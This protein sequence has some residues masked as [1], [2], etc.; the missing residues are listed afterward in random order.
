[1]PSALTDIASLADP[2]WNADSTCGLYVHEGYVYACGYVSNSASSTGGLLFSGIPSAFLPATDT[3]VTLRT[4]PGGTDDPANAALALPSTWN[5]TIHTDGT[6]TI[7]DT[8]PA[9][10]NTA[11][12]V[13]SWWYVDN[14]FPN[15]GT[16]F[17]QY[18]FPLTVTIIIGGVRWPLPGTPP[19]DSFTPSSIASDLVDFADAGSAG[20]AVHGTRVHLAGSVS[21]SSDGATLILNPL[22][23]GSDAGLSNDLHGTI[24]DGRPAYV[25]PNP[26]GAL[27]LGSDSPIQPAGD[28]PPLW[29]CSPSYRV[30]GHV[31]TNRNFITPPDALA[32]FNGWGQLCIKGHADYG[33]YSCP[34]QSCP[35]A[36]TADIPLSFDVADLLAML[37]PVPEWFFLPMQVVWSSTTAAD[38]TCNLDGTCGPPITW[39]GTPTFTGTTAADYTGAPVTLTPGSGGSFTC[40]ATPP[41]SLYTSPGGLIVN[42]AADPSQSPGMLWNSSQ[43][44]HTITFYTTGTGADVNTWDGKLTVQIVPFWEQRQDGVHAGDVL[45]LTD[46]GWEGV[47]AAGWMSIT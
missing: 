12:P 30:G 27:V 7:D 2:G 38:G 19:T 21:A 42:Q 33:T 24:I 29:T 9:S 16:H 45:D 23:T 41:S 47:L 36:G 15:D 3:A 6:W 8:I 44:P 37:N 11:P 22:P 35:Q 1:M 31:P 13:G 10:L 25:S 40:V 28:S 4:D 39:V 43:A 26:S 20:L 17:A 32:D 46:C 18:S 34:L 14:S 5:A